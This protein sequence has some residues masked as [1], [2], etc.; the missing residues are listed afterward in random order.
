MPS[1]D[2]D[3]RMEILKDDIIEGSTAVFTTEKVVKP[4]GTLITSLESLEMSIYD[5]TTGN[6]IV[7]GRDVLSGFD[8]ATSTITVTLQAADNILVDH[9]H[10]VE[11]HLLRFDFTYDAGLSKGVQ[12]Y[13][14]RVVKVLGPNRKL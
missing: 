6:E 10:A 1:V 3:T 8:T 12:P 4:D 7:V 14:F 11:K 2:Q 13:V 5:I 9:R